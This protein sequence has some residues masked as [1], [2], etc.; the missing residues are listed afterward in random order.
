MSRTKSGNSRKRAHLLEVVVV[1]L[2]L[3]AVALVAIPLSR[4][5]V[6]PTPAE[7][8]E[9]RAQPSNLHL[10][11]MR[12]LAPVAGGAASGALPAEPPVLAPSST[13]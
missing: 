3:V 9:Q 4:D 5:A 10:E 11:P 13:P 8:A 2:L 6:E 1:L 12:L 7:K